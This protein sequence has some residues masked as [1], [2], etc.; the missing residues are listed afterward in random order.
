[1][2]SDGRSSQPPVHAPVGACETTVPARGL[3]RA[4]QPVIDPRASYP[5]VAA[6]HAQPAYA[7]LH[8]YPYPYPQP[9]PQPQPYLDPR[10]LQPALAAGPAWPQQHHPRCPALAAG[11]DPGGFDAARDAAV[12]RIVWA[13][14]IVLGAVLALV[15]GKLL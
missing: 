14:V 9:Y 4:S 3:A 5:V 2:R 7:A 10:A 11:A 8:P 15:V 1:V 6:P 12:R 13:L